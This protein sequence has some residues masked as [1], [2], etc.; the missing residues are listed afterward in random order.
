M[1]ISSRSGENRGVSPDSTCPTFLIDVLSQSEK[2]VF[3]ALVTMWAAVLGWFWRWWLQADH[4]TNLTGIVVTSLLIGW[5]TL[6]PAY[7]FYFAARMKRPNPAITLPNWRMAMVVTKAPSEPWTIVRKT[8]E[9]ML[10]Q[11]YPHDTW[12]ADEAPQP[13]TIAWCQSHNVHIST[14][15]GIAAYHR[16]TWPRRTRCKE[17]NLAYFYDHYGYDHYDFVAQLDADHVPGPG[18]L[19]AILRPFIDPKVGYVAAPSICDANAHESWVVNAR[20]FAEATLHGSLQAGY[21]DGWAPLCIGSHYAVRTTALR[22]IGGLGPEL[23]ED[24]TTTLMM[25]AHGWKGGFAF[26]AEA[27]GDGP[28]CFADFLIQEYQWA[29]SLMMVLLGITPRYWRGLSP[30]LKFQFLFAQLWYPI[31]GI[32]IC[33]G[34]LLP[35]IALLVDRPWVNVIWLE[36]IVRSFVLTLACLAPVLWI[37]SRG[38]LRPQHAKV[39]SWEVVLFQFTRWP[40][41]LAGVSNAVLS[42]LLQKELPFRVTP[43]GIS[44]PKPLP[45]KALLPYLLLAGVSA[46]VT[47]VVNNV[48]HAQGYYFLSLL[49]GLLYVLITSAIVILHLHEN[50]PRSIGSRRFL[51]QRAVAMISILMM[52]GVIG[53]RL[54]RTITA[55]IDANLIPRWF[56]LS[57]HP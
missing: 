30:R 25:N 9:A 3:L 49:N 12:L 33:V 2:A 50:A 15:Q 47:I 17:G 55:N 51:Y 4:I 46:I 38:A 21:S 1:K 18:Y 8:L 45:L 43:K 42:W 16:P 37:A 41:I 11:D 23:A 28:A 34:V 48:A 40:W 27:H 44:G 39:V 13:D 5:N 6:L 20:L 36:F 24:H 53:L 7:Y 52:I 56:Q 57:E 35:P 22:Q 10:D 32:S 26:D 19:Q 14:R 31:F 29:R 54:N